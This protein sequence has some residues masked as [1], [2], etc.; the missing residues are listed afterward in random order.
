MA[1]DEKRESPTVRIGFDS[2]ELGNRTN[3]I[4]K[5]ALAKNCFYEEEVNKLVKRPGLTL[6][7]TMGG[8]CGSGLYAF[9]DSLLAIVDDEVKTVGGGSSFSAYEFRSTG[10]LPSRYAG[11]AL[12]YNNALYVMAGIG[13]GPAPYAKYVRKSTDGG[14]T[15]TE[16][17]STPAFGD[18]SDFGYC[19]HDEDVG[20][21]WAG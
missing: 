1:R 8:T 19:T 21:G 12:S 2:L 15:W 5:D 9:E 7:T 17:T 11:G 14:L 3:A 4:T 20:S 13:S 16:L 6:D 10:G 18:T